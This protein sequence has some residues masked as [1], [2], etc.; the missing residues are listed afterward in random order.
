MKFA[1]KQT[2]TFEQRK[3]IAEKLRKENPGKVTVS[4]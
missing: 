3:D 4:F 1:Y 2:H